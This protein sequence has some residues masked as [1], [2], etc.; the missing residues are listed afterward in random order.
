MSSASASS[1]ESDNDIIIHFDTDLLNDIFNRI[2]KNDSTYEY[3]YTIEGNVNVKIPFYRGFGGEFLSIKYIVIN[4]SDMLERRLESTVN[5]QQTTEAIASSPY[6]KKIIIDKA[7]VVSDPVVVGLIGGSMSIIIKSNG[8]N[9]LQPQTEMNEIDQ[10]TISFDVSYTF[11]EDYNIVYA[12]PFNDSKTIRKLALQSTLNN[13]HKEY[14]FSRAGE[15]KMLCFFK[16]TK[17]I[18]N[19]TINAQAE[20]K[21]GS[22]WNIQGI[23]YS[24]WSILQ[25][26][27]INISIHGTPGLQL[28]SGIIDDK[29]LFNQYKPSA[30][31]N[32]TTI[33]V[34]DSP[35]GGSNKYN[36]GKR[37]TRK[38]KKYKKSRKNKSRKNHRKS[39][40]HRR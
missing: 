17:N 3:N 39:H 37:K 15:D 36:G 29:V 28:A 6:I 19:Y 32:S 31:D 22:K 24:D 5:V 12:A 10:V 27:G 35:S 14:S 23:A 8:S 18:I 16:L 34:L 4:K 2:G 1:T 30:D 7:Q 20:I 40:R 13:Q 21:K 26:K 38:N 9:C 11:T 25:N 33:V